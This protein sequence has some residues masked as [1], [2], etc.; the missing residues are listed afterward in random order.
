MDKQESNLGFKT[1][2]IWYKFRDFFLP[3]EKVLQEVDIEPGF[4]I[5]DFGCGPGSYA[6]VAAQL[7]GDAGK[8]YA[9]DIHPLAIE[10][11]QKA[12]AKKGL[13]NIVAIQSDCA[14][15]LPDKSIDVVLLCDL[16]HDLNEPDKVL[17]ELHRVLKPGGILSS[18]DHHLKEDEIVAKITTGGL[19]KL[20]KKGNKVLSFVKEE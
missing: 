17:A 1:M 10:M 12:A 13:T 5:L 6:V 11:V 15:G 16:L 18:N 14:T 7:I 20:S 19:F 9:L 8:V 4:H 3:R 2:A